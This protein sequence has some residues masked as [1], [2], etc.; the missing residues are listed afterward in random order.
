MQ[1]RLFRTVGNVA[2]NYSLKKDNM[3]VSVLC[4]FAPYFGSSIVVQLFQ[5][6]KISRLSG[7]VPLCAEI[8]AHIHH[9]SLHYTQDCFQ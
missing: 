2:I 5:L 6:L 7:Q 8:V 1:R 4:L 3:S 9:F